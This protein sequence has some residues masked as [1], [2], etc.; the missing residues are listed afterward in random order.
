MRLSMGGEM[1]AL[2]RKLRHKSPKAARRSL[3][4]ISLELAKAGYISRSG[5]PYALTAIGRTL[6]RS[7]D[8]L[9]GRADSPRLETEQSLRST[10]HWPKHQKGSNEPVRRSQMTQHLNFTARATL[11]KLSIVK[12]IWIGLIPVQ[13]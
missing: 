10:D 9:A 5:K 11:L 1:I 2:S 8:R 4:E 6:G 7:S 12:I 13:P 3:R